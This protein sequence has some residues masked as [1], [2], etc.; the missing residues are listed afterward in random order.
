M[1]MLITAFAGCT[2][3]EAPAPVS[4]RTAIRLALEESAYSR[5]KTRAAVSVF[6][7]DTIA[8]A[9]GSFSGTYSEIWKAKGE[10]SE[11]I[12]LQPRYYPE[13][14][15]RL[16]LR[17]YYPAA[18]PDINGVTWHLD[19]SQ[20]VMVSNEQSG[21]LTDMFWQ[22]NKKFTFTHLL[23][24]LNIRVRVEDNFPAGARLTRMQIGGS[25]PDVLLD[26]NKGVLLPLGEP[27]VLTVWEADGPGVSLSGTFPDAPIAT[28]MLEAGVPLT[29]F[30]TVTL[31]DGTVWDY[32][33]LPIHFAEADGLPQAGV[34]YTLSVVLDAEKEKLTLSTTVTDWTEREGGEVKI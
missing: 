17:G 13:D 25:H 11:A 16:F 24:R 18:V 33:A 28:A 29:F 4:V 1:S 30:A 22:D 15:S 20:D 2:V 5:Q 27:A 7:G 3:P 19:G 31:S 34:S 26:L 32:E 12:P 21:S 9:V 6:N 8:F 23:T 10:G 14:G